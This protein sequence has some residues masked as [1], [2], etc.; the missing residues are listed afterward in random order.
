MQEA[1]CEYALANDTIE[2]EFESTLFN[3]DLVIT[4]PL[5]TKNTTT[6]RNEPFKLA[7]K[8]RLLLMLFNKVSFPL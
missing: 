4:Y 5:I 3:I 8:I 7:W 2:N 6:P 1:T